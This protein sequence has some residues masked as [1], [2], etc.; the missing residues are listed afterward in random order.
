MDNTLP[1]SC[2]LLQQTGWRGKT[3]AARHC[4]RKRVSY[5]NKHATHPDFFRSPVYYLICMLGTHKQ[6]A[7]V[8]TTKHFSTATQYQTVSC[9]LFFQVRRTV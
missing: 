1:I 2:R 4:E 9:P 7:R 5:A 8:S 3:R 6:Y